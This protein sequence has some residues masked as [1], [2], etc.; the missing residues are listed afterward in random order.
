MGVLTIEGTT[1]NCAL[2]SIE[3]LTLFEARSAKGAPLEIYRALPPFN[4]PSFAEGL[5]AD[6]RTLFFKPGGI[7]STGHLEQGDRLC[8]YTSTEG[9]TD[10]FPDSAGCFRLSTYDQVPAT[11]A[12]L[13]VQTR[14]VAAHSCIERGNSLLARNLSLTG[15]GRSGYTLNLRL[16]TAEPLPAATP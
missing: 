5:V 3:G 6:I 4:S 11:G 10:I 8:R 13:P 7:L 2:L 9:V 14:S 16:L 12:A 1:L 15:L